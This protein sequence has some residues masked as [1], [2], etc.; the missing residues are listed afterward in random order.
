MTVKHLTDA[1]FELRVADLQRRDRADL[2]RQAK[3][4]RAL[5]LVG[6]DI[7][8]ERAEEKLLAS[9]VIG[10]YDPRTKELVVRGGSATAAVRHVVVHELTHA[11]QDQWFDLEGHQRGLGDDASEAYAALVEGDAVRIEQEY[12]DGLPAQDR[13]ELQ[14]SATGGSLPADV[15]R[16]LVGLLSFPY[17]A[18]PR[19][20]QALL[21]AGGQAGLDRAFQSP[22]PATSLVLHPDRYLVGAALKDVP[23]PP[24]D[25]PAFDHGTVGELG[26]DLLLQDLFASGVLSL[27]TVR[28]ATD[29]WEG[30][31]YVAWTSGSRYCLRA[32]FA[33]RDSASAQALTDA[34]QRWA[35]VHPGAS[36]MPGAQPALT[37]CA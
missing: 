14:R 7:D 6:P 24:A 33:L 20:V 22:P 26:R 2:D 31:R 32:R 8:V 29:G 36:V 10:Y 23:E 37:S 9:Q 28:A 30:D 19:F 25:G 34:L 21:T 13:Q 16:V 12:I 1:A 3:V 15:P 17:A 5:G 4:L 11:L 35:A 18:G 27:S